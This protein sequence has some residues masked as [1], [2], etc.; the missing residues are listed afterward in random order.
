MLSAE[1]TRTAVG[2]SLLPFALGRTGFRTALCPA[3]AGCARRGRSGRPPMSQAR[4]HPYVVEEHLFRLIV[5]LERRKALRAQYA[6][7]PLTIVRQP[8]QDITTSPGP[9]SARRVAE[10]GSRMTRP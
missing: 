7:S 1:R 6:F 5:E 9:A 4:P 3:R 10:S 2:T 8:P